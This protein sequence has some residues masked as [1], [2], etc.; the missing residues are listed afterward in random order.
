MIW[1][2]PPGNYVQKPLIFWGVPEKASNMI[3]LSLAMR[4]W[5]GCHLCM[6]S[7][8]Q[9]WPL[10]VVPCWLLDEPPRL[11]KKNGVPA[12]KSEIHESS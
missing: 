10:V 6:D 2:K 12:T 7:W 5:S 4:G 9:R 11:L 8:M 1:T 3:P